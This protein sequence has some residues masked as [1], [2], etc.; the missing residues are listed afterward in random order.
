MVFVLV[1][2]CGSFCSFFSSFFSLV[3][4]SFWCCGFLILFGRFF[5]GRLDFV[6]F[7]TR[8]CEKFWY[9]AFSGRGFKQI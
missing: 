2:V 4:P 3:F 5:C 8:F 1:L 9:L 7:F 6:R